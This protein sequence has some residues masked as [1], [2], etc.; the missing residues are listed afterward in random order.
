M[1]SPRNMYIWPQ[2]VP[3][4]FSLSLPSCPS[5]V[6]AT[7]EG[8][9]GKDS[10]N[11]HDHREKELAIERTEIRLLLR[12]KDKNSPFTTWQGQKFA[13]Y[14]VART[15]IRH[16]LPGK[17]RNSPSTTWQG[18]KFA[19]YNV[20]R[21]EIPHPLPGKDK[22]TTACPC[23]VKGEFRSLPRSKSRIFVLAR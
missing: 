17:D 11:S 15:E 18:Q 7:W 13:F 10:K 5:Q 12:G 19:I 2:P 22:K 3:P 1:S 6:L 16:L 21:T 8:Q 14:Y 20:A 23:H 4:K 9:H